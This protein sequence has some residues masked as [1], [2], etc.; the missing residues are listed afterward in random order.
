MDDLINRTTRLLIDLE[1]VGEKKSLTSVLEKII[2]NL[3]SSFDV[4]AEV[5]RERSRH[6]A[7]NIADFWASLRRKDADLSSKSAHD[8]ASTGLGAFTV[9][10][11][12]ESSVRHSGGH[13]TNHQAQYQRDGATV[14]CNHCGRMG[15]MRAECRSRLAGRAPAPGSVD[16]KRKHNGGGQNHGKPQGGTS[17]AAFMAGSIGLQPTSELPSIDN[18]GMMKWSMDSG[19]THTNTPVRECIHEF[20]NASRPYSIVRDAR[21]NE[22]EV[23]G[24]GKVK[25]NGG[26]DRYK[27]RIVVKGYAQRAGIDFDDTND[28]WAPVSK[29]ESVRSFLATAATRNWTV[30]QVD[31]KTAFLNAELTEEIYIRLPEE[32]DGG[33]QVYRLRKALYGLKQASRAWYEKLK[34]MMTSFDWTAS[35]ADPAF[36][37][38]ETAAA[39][40]EG[41][42]CHVDDMLIGSTVLAN[43]IELKQQLGSMVEIKDLGVANY[44]LA[45]EVQQRSDK[46]LLTQ[47]KY[48]SEILERFQV[49]QFEKKHTPMDTRQLSVEDGDLLDDQSTAKY[50]EMTGCLMYVCRGTRPDI[51]YSVGVLARYMKQPRTLHLKA[52]MDILKYLAA[53][54]LMGIEYGGQ[55][56][57]FVGYSGSDLG[58][59]R[60]DSRSTTG[61]AFMLNGGAVSWRSRLQPT[62]ADS[63]CEAEFMAAADAI[64]EALWFKKLLPN[65]GVIDEDEAVKIMC[66]NESAEAVLR[67]PRI[68]EVSKHISRK[69][70]FAKESV[71]LNEVKIEHVSTAKQVAD[72]FTKPLERQKFEA[73]RLALGVKAWPV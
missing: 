5:E 16:S 23:R 35:D 62:I 68:N 48:I 4:W 66:D 50:R 37:W 24:H 19:S 32:V 12:H 26:F 61:F 6:D 43:V 3:P 31:V 9:R 46:L 28:T 1:L 53:T 33:T 56:D 55:K 36:F 72:I 60:D 27:A 14:T 51:A 41:V 69:W 21:G 29:L 13:N 34:D 38:R 15:H 18:M 70:N 11:Q 2:R 52:A 58:G 22:H 45:T 63:S 71:A 40:Y 42:C 47:Q 67:S 65:L 44:Y 10:K 25:A 49:P 64:K 7:Y 73:G 59:C 57:T 30:H 8:S 17:G 39:G 54:K 20:V